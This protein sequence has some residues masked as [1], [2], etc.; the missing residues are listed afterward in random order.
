MIKEFKW[1]I[2]AALGAT[3]GTFLSVPYARRIPTSLLGDTPFGINLGAI[4]LITVVVGFFFGLIWGG[5]EYYRKRF[6][7]YQVLGATFLSPV[8]Y[9]LTY[10]ILYNSIIYLS[11]GA[12]E[13]FPNLDNII[14]ETT[15]FFFWG[16]VFGGG[17]LLGLARILYGKQYMHFNFWKTIL[18]FGVLG[19]MAGL[20]FELQREA[21][22]PWYV[23]HI[24]WHSAA[25]PFVLSRFNP[26]PQLGTRW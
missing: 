22:W 7:F 1:A 10:L 14:G 3:F 5:I 13:L 24:T 18:G 20:F 11:V 12:R 9:S 15:D 19:G 17:L 25:L 2:L 26:V 6:K 8:M 21:N 4:F 23:L 16:G